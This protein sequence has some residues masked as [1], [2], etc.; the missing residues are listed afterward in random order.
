MSF[1]EWWYNTNYHSSIKMT[2]FQ[3]LYSYDSPQMA[4]E[5]IQTFVAA[6]EDWVKERQK[7]NEMLTTTC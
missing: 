2:P 7:W 4:F 6:I 5:S 3:A 1:A